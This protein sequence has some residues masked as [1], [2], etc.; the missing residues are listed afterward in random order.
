MRSVSPPHLL[1]VVA[2]VARA[3]FLFAH[4]DDEYA[5]I[6]WIREEIAGGTAVTCLYLTSGGS[7]A[8]P[9][10]R[11]AESRRVLRSQGV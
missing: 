10:V 5:A 11:D 6:P 3:L 1:T 4:Q 2:R 8:D 9:A 7:R